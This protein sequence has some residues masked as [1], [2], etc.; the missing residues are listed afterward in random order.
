M[1]S[2]EASIIILIA[3]IL[4]MMVATA[5]CAYDIGYDK[6]ATRVENYRRSKQLY[7]KTFKFTPSE[8]SCFYNAYR[9]LASNVALGKLNC[10][11][12]PNAPWENGC[13]VIIAKDME[14]VICQLGELSKDNK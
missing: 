11:F 5:I 7:R 6:C 10:T 13:Y 2:K 9:S 12:L 3:F 14:D 8:W 4:V 1:S